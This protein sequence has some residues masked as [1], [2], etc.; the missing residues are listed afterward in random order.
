MRTPR[1]NAATE[2]NEG[3][4]VLACEGVDAD[5]L[6]R[7]VRMFEMRTTCVPFGAPTR[8]L[9]ACRDVGADASMPRASPRC[10]YEAAPVA[11]ARSVSEYLEQVEKSISVAAI[12]ARARVRQP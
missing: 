1:L 12:K 10:S 3:S 8:A 7:D 5:R 11:E 2:V 9:Q 4:L 6:S